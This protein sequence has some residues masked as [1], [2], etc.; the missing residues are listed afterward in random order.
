MASSEP[1]RAIAR[2][3]RKSPFALL[4]AGRTALREVP[5]LRAFLIKGFLLNYGVFIVTAA[6]AMILI[7]WFLVRPVGE[8]LTAWSMGE[9]FFWGLVAWLLKVVLWVT[10]LLLMAATLMLSLL[11]AMALMTLWFEALVGRIVAHC[12][13]ESE[14]AGGA[15][16]LREWLGGLGRSIRD[17]VWLMV[18]A[19][20]A[21]GFGFIPVVGPVLVVL[22]DGYLLGWE[23][24]EPYL[25]VREEYGDERRALRK[26]LALWT[27][28]TGLLPVVLAMIP[29]V[30]WLL[31][32][33]VLIYLV[34][35][36]AWQGE[37]AL[38]S[39]AA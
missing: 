11:F 38:R 2:L 7:Y 29:I 10:Q 14:G 15:F 36:F 12:R 21:L 17:S 25:T 30:G 13:Q 34:A 27:V 26:G 33:A 39:E 22:F 20:L 16:S 18:L 8:G 6:A 4:G 1:T 31:L 19:L 35:G 5:G 32:P 24:R 23:I 28:Q 37:Q 3:P 9:G